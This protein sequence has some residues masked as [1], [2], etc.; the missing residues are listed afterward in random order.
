MTA[1]LPDHGKPSSLVDMLEVAMGA[2]VGNSAPVNDDE[3]AR[4]SF[5]IPRTVLEE[6]SALAQAN[7]MSMSLLINLLLD[8]YLKEQGRLGYASVA[9]WYAEYALRK[10]SEG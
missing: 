8:A 10:K 6:V 5:R 7:R 3:I 4:T 1:P 9:P 2:D